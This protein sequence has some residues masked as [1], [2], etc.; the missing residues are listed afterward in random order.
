MKRIHSIL[1]IVGAVCIPAATVAALDIPHTFEP[2][3][4]VSASSMNQNFDAVKSEVETLQ[5]MV[6]ELQDELASSSGFSLTSCEWHRNQCN[7]PGEC[8]AECP[9]GM[10]PIGGACDG[11]NGSLMETFVAAS[12]FPNDTPHPVTDFDRWICEPATGA[13]INHANVLCCPVD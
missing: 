4:P 11:A 10:H 6:A 2:G 13:D 12:P 3:D 8:T 9:S 7:G 5:T 1:G